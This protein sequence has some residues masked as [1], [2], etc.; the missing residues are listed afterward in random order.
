MASEDARRIRTRLFLPEGAEAGLIGGGAVAL[1]FLMRDC[2][3]GEP[4][5]T[6][7]VLGMLVLSGVEAAREVRSATGA[8]V[9]YNVAHFTVWMV[10]GFA[11]SAL[12]KLAET[13][14]GLRPLPLLLVLFAWNRVYPLNDKTAI[15]ELAEMPEI[16]SRFGARLS[17]V[18]ASVGADPAGQTAS[19]AAM[20]RLFDEVTALVGPAYEAPSG[21]PA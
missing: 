5:H 15:E 13:R 8:A 17:A 10:A 12:M 7:S 20:R 11:A 9:I 4:L 6:P 18:L 19:I 21:P 2:A 14:E 3:I 16:P 1:V